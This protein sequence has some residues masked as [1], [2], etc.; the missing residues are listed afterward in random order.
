MGL[1]K[2]YTK[3]QRDT[4]DVG[5]TTP[6]TNSGFYTT[7]LNK[8]AGGDHAFKVAYNDGGSAATITLTDFD[9]DYTSLSNVPASF[10]PSAHTHTVSEI[11][12]FAVGPGIQLLTGNTVAIQTDLRDGITEVGFTATYIKFDNANNYLDFYAGGALVGRLDDDGNLKVTGDVTA[13]ATL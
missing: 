6:V 7:F 5:Q 4:V 3:I 2:S 12:D 1:K 9:G 10:T 11:S 8:D 13:F